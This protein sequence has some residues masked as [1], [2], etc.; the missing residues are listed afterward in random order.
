MFAAD[1][2]LELQRLVASESADTVGGD[3][4]LATGALLVASTD[5]PNVDIDG[6]RA[7]LDRMADAARG[8]MPSEP[9]PLEELNAITDLLFG[10]IGF[11]GN[12]DDYYDPNNSY[13]NQVLERRLGIPI[14]LSL[15]CMEVGRRAGVPVLGIGMPGHFLVRHRDEENY[16][17]DAFNG[18]L[19]MNR[20]ECGAVLRQAAGEDARLEEHHLNPV[21]PREILA[22]VLRNLKAIY[23]DREEF[24][25]CI[26]TIGALMAV[27][28]DRPEE[29]R[30]RGVVHLKAGNHQQSADDFAAYIEA[31]PH[32]DDIETVR[33]A[34]SRLRGTLS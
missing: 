32:A 21:T 34:L 7:N 14:T 8:R 9:R 10:V 28:P 26:T 11:S 27:L 24:D 19:L 30:D 4:D 13:L 1:A 29:Q 15:L 2:I 6:C 17:V 12:R 3:F 18:G 20:D 25:R 31:A 16:F 23:W 33:N 5:D 22:R